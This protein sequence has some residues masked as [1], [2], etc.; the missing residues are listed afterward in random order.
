MHNG[1]PR[2]YGQS[3]FPFIPFTRI[4]FIFHSHITA[5]SLLH[6]HTN[7]TFTYIKLETYKRQIYS[8]FLCFDLTQQESPR[9][10]PLS[11]SESCSPHL[12]T[13]P[14]KDPS[15]SRPARRRSPGSSW[16]SPATSP[17][18]R[19]GSVWKGR[20]DMKNCWVKDGEVKESRKELRQAWKEEEVD[21]RWTGGTRT[22]CKCVWKGMKGRTAG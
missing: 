11:L 18:I 5:I 10:S 9:W 22:G 7:A 1:S 12:C 4:I 19:W 20:N 17:Q 13:S 2:T 3:F 6:Q 21:K 8:Y 15:P 16:I 14:T